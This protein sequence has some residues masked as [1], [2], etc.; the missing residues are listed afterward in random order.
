MKIKKN[1]QY[2]Y[3]NLNKCRSRHRQYKQLNDYNSI[4]YM[5]RKDTNFYKQILFKKF[6]LNKNQRNFYADGKNNNFE[7]IDPII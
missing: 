1:I 4:H 7:K 6:G 2:Y 3:N 5:P